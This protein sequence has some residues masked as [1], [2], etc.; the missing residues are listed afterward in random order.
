MAKSINR[1]ILPILRK[2]ELVIPGKH[3]VYDFGDNTFEKRIIEV[4]IKYIGTS[5]NEL[6]TRARS[7]ASWL[8]GFNGS[9]RLIF[10]DES[11]KYY[12]AKIY[13]EIGLN[14]L[15][16]I[17][18]G[19]LIFE[20]DPFAYA[21]ETTGYY[22]TWSANLTW[23][24]SYTWGQEYT[25]IVTANVTATITN[26]ATFTARPSFIIIGSF[27]DFSITQG[28][29][30][31]TYTEAVSGSQTVTIDSENY[32]VVLGATNKLSVISGSASTDFFE[33]TTGSNTVIFSGI[34]ANCTV[35]IDFAPRYL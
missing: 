11:D 35:T 25:F 4:D 22:Y 16:K 20:C 3:G 13:S 26:N 17:G 23:T 30:T 14:N 10:D 15:F 31:L 21:L 5:F 1:P 28:T 7:I 8:S 24:S 32:T 29:A 12:S 18:E 19:K 6:R 27:G 2:R 34:S 33:F 9:Q